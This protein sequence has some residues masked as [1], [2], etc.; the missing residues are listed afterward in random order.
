MYINYNKKTAHRFLSAT[1]LPFSICC[2]YTV[3]KEN[4]KGVF[5]AKVGFTLKQYDGFDNRY[6]QK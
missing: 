5:V 1:P 2:H 6:I 4:V 3:L